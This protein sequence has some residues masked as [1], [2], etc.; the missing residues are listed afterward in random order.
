LLEPQTDGESEGRMRSNGQNV[1]E[2]VETGDNRG[3]R[4]PATDAAKTIFHWQNQ[5]TLNQ[6]L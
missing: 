6:M 1:S 2:P 3:G 5:S 4:Q